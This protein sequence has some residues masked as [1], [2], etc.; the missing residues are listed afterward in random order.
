M[1][2]DTGPFVAL[3]DRSEK[4]HDACLGAFQ[5]FRGRLL[6]TEPVL[7]ETLYLLGP[8]FSLQKPALEFILSGG[9]E[10]ASLTT[11]SLR[12]AMQLMEK[13]ADVPMDF[14]D[15]TLVALA[16]ETGIHRVFTLDRRGFSAYRVGSRKSF[17][18]V[19]GPA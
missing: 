18:I 16:E 12:R 15:A 10:L 3:L 1:L 2:L 4:N 6:T 14:A 8:A 11:K 19:P 9:A 17:T 5:D 7:T 13:Y